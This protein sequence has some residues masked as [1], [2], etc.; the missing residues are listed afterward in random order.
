MTLTL[1]D[2][3]GG[4]DA[5]FDP[6]K[7]VSKYTIS[8]EKAIVLLNAIA[9]FCVNTL[10]SAVSPFFPQ[11][12]VISLGAS[13]ELVGLCLAAFPLASMMTGSLAGWACSRLG[14]GAVA[15]AGA[16][17]LAAG[18][19]A[20]GLS[21]TMPL[22]MAAR[23][24][25]GA[26]AAAIN[27][28]TT[29]LMMSVMQADFKSGLAIQQM[30]VGLGYILGPSL[31]GGVY[32]LGGFEVTFLVLACLPLTLALVMP[33]LLRAAGLPLGH[34]NPPSTVPTAPA[35]PAQGDAE[36]SGL[37]DATCP[38]TAAEGKA[39]TPRPSWRGALLLVL[40][41]G[42][43]LACCSC[44][45]L[46]SAA[47]GFLDS[48]FE[49]HLEQSLGT[50]PFTTG[51]TYSLPAV[52]YSLGSLLT[53]PVVDR[54]GFQR[55]IMAGLVVMAAAMWLIGPLPLLGFVFFDRAVTWVIWIAALLAL[56]LGIAL[57]LV[58]SL[59]AM[60]ASVGLRRGA[61]AAAG[62]AEEDEAISDATS[63]VYTGFMNAGEVL[64]PVIGASAV[65]RMWQ[66]KE[67]TCTLS[68]EECASGFAWAASAFGL[69]ILLC[70]LMIWWAVPRHLG[71]ARAHAP[72]PAPSKP[73][74]KPTVQR[75]AALKGGKAH[76]SGGGGGGGAAPAVAAAHGSAVPLR[77]ALLQ[78]EP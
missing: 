1:Q 57:L 72:M 21:G 32:E 36:A 30:F 25:Q 39:A 26:G 19:L 47:F 60:Q 17:A 31:G 66:V 15:M 11:Y 4:R 9:A 2:V 78:E 71:C 23:A 63:T 8:S 69:I 61:A 40:R 41:N 53:V 28:S 33:T 3:G 37:E 62:A 34:R 55:C 49:D 77:Q 6:A 5:V 58:P 67:V 51:L 24:L 70:A 64:G 16:L 76:A 48:T 52:T 13:G 29:A 22:C 44:A 50:T 43:A 38:P 12:A 56:G 20:F 46:F 42:G 18:T 27:I 74:A 14:R 68:D 73:P 45:L 59:P 54:V 75:A 7:S 35:S 10:I 65:A